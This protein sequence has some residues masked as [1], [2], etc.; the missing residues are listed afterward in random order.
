MPLQYN[1]ATEAQL[2]EITYLHNKS[3]AFRSLEQTL[4]A[5][6]FSQIQF[7]EVSTQQIRY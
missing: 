3:A 2:R 4:Q 5:R 1:G 6:G 7:V